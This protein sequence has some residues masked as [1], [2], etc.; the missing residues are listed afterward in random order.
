MLL[1][2]T[3]L[4]SGEIAMEGEVYG[5]WPAKRRKGFISPSA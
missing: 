4:T 5:G 3:L 2:H 1:E